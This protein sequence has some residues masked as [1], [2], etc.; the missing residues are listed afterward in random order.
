MN[1]LLLND[2]EITK[3]AITGSTDPD[4]LDSVDAVRFGYLLMNTFLSVESVYLKSHAGL[5][6]LER[7]PAYEVQLANLVRFPGIR[8][9]WEAT[10]N[11]FH[12]GF[13]ELVADLIRKVDDES[14]RE[15]SE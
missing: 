8:A 2:R 9:W 15:V 1:E 3:L 6:Q 10:D 12:S 5:L 13:S 4:A 11:G 14:A 7:W